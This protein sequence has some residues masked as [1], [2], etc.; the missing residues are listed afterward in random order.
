MS[1]WLLVQVTINLALIL[2][3]FSL[4]NSIRKTRN[5]EDPRMSRGLQLLQSKISVI[6]DLSDRTEVQVKQVTALL[7]GKIKELHQKIE[8]ADK[9]VVEVERS[10]AKSLEVSKI[11]Q[12]KIPHQEIIE[13]QATAKYIEAAR[14]ANRGVSIDEIASQV[15][16][17]RGELELIVRMNRTQ[18]VFNESEVPD[19]VRPANVPQDFV[20]PTP[21]PGATTPSP[22]LRDLERIREQL[23]AFSDTPRNEIPSFEDFTAGNTG[24]TTAPVVEEAPTVDRAAALNKLAQARSAVQN[25]PTLAESVLS[26]AASTLNPTPVPT[27]RPL[28]P[29]EANF[30]PTPVAKNQAA[31]FGLRKTSVLPKDTVTKPYEF[32]KIKVDRP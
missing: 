11:F 6:E 8:E 15:A 7:S 14:L 19:W 28:N 10:I 31:T 30:K 3:I 13:R 21:E 2:G 18:L 26:A 4:W 23:R 17:P 9:H 20:Q 22:A 25:S 12:D 24:V 1:I 16:I 32:K 27:S 29:S 5:S